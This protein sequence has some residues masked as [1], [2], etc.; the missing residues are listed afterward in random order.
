MLLG[1]IPLDPGHERIERGLD[2]LAERLHD[3]FGVGVNRLLGEAGL[4]GITLLFGLE[5]GLRW[6]LVPLGLLLFLFLRHVL[7]IAVS[8]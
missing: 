7:I 6:W 5:D 8:R 4:V 3:L 2:L 1:V